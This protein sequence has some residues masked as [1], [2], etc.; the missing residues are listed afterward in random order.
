MS[1]SRKDAEAVQDAATGLSIRTV[2]MGPL[3]TNAYLLARGAEALIVD[4]GGDPSGVLALLRAEGLTLRQV[5]CTHLHFDHIYG[6]RALATATGATILAGADD[7]FLLA[8][9]LGGG[10]FMGFPPVERF[11]YQPLQ[12]GPTTFLGLECQV[13]A[14][15]GHTPGSLTYVFPEAGVAFVGDVIFY[16][17]VGRTDFPGGDQQVLLD[18]IRQ[19]IFTLPDATVLYPGHGPHTTVGDEKKNNPYAGMFV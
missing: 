11:D 7:E 16:R 6:N 10:G 14:T 5:L 2:P 4:P 8:S 13:L 1:R 19:R 12:P 15:P 3:E 9:E 17:S 18:S